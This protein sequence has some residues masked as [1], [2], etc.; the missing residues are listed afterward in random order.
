MAPKHFLEEFYASFNRE[1]ASEEADPEVVV[2]QYYTPDC[3]QTTDGIPMDRARLLAHL[4]PVGK[5]LS[6]A[7]EERVEV[8]EALADGSRIAARI[9]IR[10]TPAEG[11]PIVMEVQMIGELSEDGRFRRTHGLTR[12]VAA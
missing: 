8:H 5:L 7:R 2:D 4:S 3:V 6:T 10:V 1:I 11:E 9:T 12:D